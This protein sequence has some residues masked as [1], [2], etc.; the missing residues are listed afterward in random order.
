M[1]AQRPF[2]SSEATRCFPCPVVRSRILR[3]PAEYPRSSCGVWTELQRKTHDEAR[4]ECSRGL[5][6]G[7]HVGVAGIT[8]LA[9]SY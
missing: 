1:K 3:Q 9:T 2:D 8:E 7:F 5:S 4:K 6:E